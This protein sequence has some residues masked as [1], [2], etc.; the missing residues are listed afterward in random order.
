MNPNQHAQKL[1]ARAEAQKHL[2]HSAVDRMRE[3]HMAEHTDKD[4]AM[5]KAHK[6]RAMKVKNA[7]NDYAGEEP[8]DD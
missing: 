4:E 3:A 7:N 6:A 5:E 8:E 2:K 1:R